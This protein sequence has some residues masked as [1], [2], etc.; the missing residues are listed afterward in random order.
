MR[1]AKD[2]ALL[3]RDLVIVSVIYLGMWLAGAKHLPG[4][5]PG[6][7]AEGDY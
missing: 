3:V 2:V 5:G 7:V 1:Q 4:D 6:D